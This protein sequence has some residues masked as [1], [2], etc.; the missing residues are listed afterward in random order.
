VY[1]FFAYPFNPKETRSKLGVLFGITNKKIYSAIKTGLTK[2]GYDL[3]GIEVASSSVTRAFNKLGAQGGEGRAFAHFD[4]N[5]AHLL[6]THNGVPLLFREV[7]FE[8]AQSTERRRLDVRGSVDFINKQLGTTVFSEILLSGVSL[9]SWKGV[10]EEDSKLTV[11]IW[12]PKSVVNLQ[13][14]DWGTFAAVGSTLRYMP[15]EAGHLDLVEKERVSI[16]DKKAQLF[17]YLLAC[18]AAGFV[19][20]LSGM[21]Y[22][23]LLSLSSTISKLKKNTPQITEFEGKVPVQISELVA[24]ITEKQDKLASLLTTDAALTPKLISVTDVIPQ[25]GWISAISYSRQVG[26]GSGLTINGGVQTGVAQ[27]DVSIANTIMENLKREPAMQLYTGA[28]NK[29]SYTFAKAKD[30]NEATTFEIKCQ[31]VK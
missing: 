17:A 6:L 14:M 5:V 29:F 9:E 13:E 11:K 10:I 24:Q 3:V 2:I 8:D 4:A 1:D 22:T 12:D 31:E 30:E 7:S 23:K 16:D 20:I 18:S 28:G 25:H 21:Q 26:V 27:E 19:L 15:D